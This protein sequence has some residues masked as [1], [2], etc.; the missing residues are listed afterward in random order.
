MFDYLLLSSLCIEPLTLDPSY[1][2]VAGGTAVLISGLLFRRSDE[3]KCT[4]DGIGVEGVYLSDQ[5]VLCTSPQLSRTGRV[6]VQL[7]CN[8]KL[9]QRDGVF[10]SSKYN[11]IIMLH[12]VKKLFIMT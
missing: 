1:G 3:I 9:L 4:F 5:Q 10:Y 8:G 6:P 7:Y 2:N 11:R 12:F